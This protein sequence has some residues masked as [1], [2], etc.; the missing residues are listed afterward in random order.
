[1]KALRGIAVSPGY[2]NGRVVVYRP[3]ALDAVQGRSIEP[4]EVEGE[5]DRF[6]VAV[7]RAIEELSVVRQQ[8]AAD[9]GDGEAAIFD[10][11]IA[12]LSDSS[13]KLNIHE[14]LKKN[15]CVPKRRL[16]P[17]CR[18]LPK[19]SHHRVAT[20]CASLPW[21]QKMSATA[22]FGTSVWMRG[23]ARWLSSLR[24]VLFLREI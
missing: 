20:I 22:C 16:R 3:P 18:L 19:G 23:K 17:K 13:L 7:D 15:E 5:F 11:H 8:V 2:A 9:V 21:M 14:R 4:E 24:T 12:M 1:M 6:T 10:A